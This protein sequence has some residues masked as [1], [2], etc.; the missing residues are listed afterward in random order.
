MNERDKRYESGR[1]RR[2]RSRKLSLAPVFNHCQFLSSS[3]Q[4]TTLPLIFSLL[5]PHL[6]C[7][8]RPLLLCRLVIRFCLS[9]YK[10]VK[11]HPGEVPKESNEGQTRERQ[12]GG[13]RDRVGKKN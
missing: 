3:R 4:T 8:L 12:H 9:P 11:L 13:R 5:S 7:L 10:S 6:R 2:E 1:D